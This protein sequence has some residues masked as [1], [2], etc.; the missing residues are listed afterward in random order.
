LQLCKFLDPKKRQIWLKVWFD[1][2]ENA[3][4]KNG[5][6]FE[7]SEEVENDEMGQLVQEIYF[8]R[9]SCSVTSTTMSDCSFSSF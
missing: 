2:L 6:F 4:M 9:R 3:E 8:S 5:E 1:K 7:V